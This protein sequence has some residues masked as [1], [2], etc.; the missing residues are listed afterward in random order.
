MND[1]TKDELLEIHLTLVG[2]DF[3]NCDLLGKI[4]SMIDNYCDDVIE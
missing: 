2:Y 4:Q 1:F 3:D